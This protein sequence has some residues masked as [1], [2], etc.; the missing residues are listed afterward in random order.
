MLVSLWDVDNKIEVVAETVVIEAV[1]P[2]V[3]ALA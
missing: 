3:I 1:V 2:V